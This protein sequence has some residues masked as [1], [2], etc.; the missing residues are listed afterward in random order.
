MSRYVKLPF[1]TERHAR[2][3]FRRGSGS[4]TIIYPDVATPDHVSKEWLKEHKCNLP[5]GTVVKVDEVTFVI[6]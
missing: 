2:D 4:I 3:V 1:R 6:T 5:Y